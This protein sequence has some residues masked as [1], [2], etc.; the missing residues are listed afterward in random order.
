M[1]SVSLVPSFISMKPRTS[2]GFTPGW[3]VTQVSFAVMGVYE[4]RTRSPFSVDQRVW[5]ASW[6][7]IFLSSG[8]GWMAPRFAASAAKVARP[9]RRYTVR[10]FTFGLTI[11]S[12][13]CW[14]NGIS[15]VGIK[16]EIK[17][18]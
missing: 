15:P 8:S 11:C 1:A 13:V 4:S 14:I 18:A 5:G 12:S 7:R 17:V 6:L 2:P 16:F 9:S 10:S 3:Q